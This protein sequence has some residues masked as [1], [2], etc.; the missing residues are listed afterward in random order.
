MVMIAITPAIYAQDFDFEDESQAPDTVV[1]T[2]EGFESSHAA[3]NAMSD[4]FGMR[5]D[6]SYLGDGSIESATMRG[7]LYLSIRLGGEYN[8]LFKS[9]T[10]YPAAV[11]ELGIGYRTKRL[12]ARTYFGVATCQY[13]NYSDRRAWYFAP[14]MSVEVLGEVA[15]DHRFE[16]N[17]FK[18]G[19][20]IDYKLRRTYVEDAACKFNFTGSYPGVGLALEYERQFWGSRS[21]IAVCAHI[22]TDCEIGNGKSAWGI[23][24]T[25]SIAYRIGVQKKDVWKSGVDMR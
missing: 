4:K 8:Y 22:G 13:G 14:R 20:F 9:K 21:S 15:C 10:N 3:M 5:Y 23:A 16:E 12:D 11:G 24:G 7:G 25:V 17:S 1:W 18:I 19:G 2:Q 6:I